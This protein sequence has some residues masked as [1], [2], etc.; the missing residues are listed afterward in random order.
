[1]RT[2]LIRVLKSDNYTGVNDKAGMVRLART[3]SESTPM[4]P[5]LKVRYTYVKGR[6][7]GYTHWLTL[8]SKHYKILAE[9]TNA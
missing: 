4:H 2:Y 9:I 7:K 6:S 8:G 1:M 5:L 3:H